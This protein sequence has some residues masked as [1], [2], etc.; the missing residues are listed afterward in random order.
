MRQSG[1]LDSADVSQQ[2]TKLEHFERQFAPQM[3]GTART[4]DAGSEFRVFKR[5]RVQ[6]DAD[7]L[8]VG[9]VDGEEPVAKLVDHF[10]VETS[11]TAFHVGETL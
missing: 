10:G 1:E 4:Q 9:R 8:Q 6:L 3:N 2:R 11:E 7:S 5:F